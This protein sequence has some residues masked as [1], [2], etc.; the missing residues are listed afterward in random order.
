MFLYFFGIVT[1]SW[2][3]LVQN[4]IMKI[5]L[6]FVIKVLKWRILIGR[7]RPLTSD[8]SDVEW[9]QMKKKQKTAMT[10]LVSTALFWRDITL[11]ITVNLNDLQEIKLI[12]K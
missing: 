8:N 4:E 11:N 12:H 3:E 5:G 1:L 6:N 7:W 9:R 2:I 10:S